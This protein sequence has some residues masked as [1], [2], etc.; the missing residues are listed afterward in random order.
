M[1]E[2]HTGK[3]VAYYRVS[4]SGRAAAVLGWRRSRPPSRTTSM[5]AT[6]AWWLK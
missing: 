4:T 3:F 6:G 5:A 1:T 2:A